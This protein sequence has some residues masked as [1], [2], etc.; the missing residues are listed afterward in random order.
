M[1]FRLRAIDF[2]QEC[3]EGSHLIYMPQFF[4]ENNPIINLGIKSMSP[5]LEHQYQREERMR[6]WIRVQ[7]A[8]TQLQTMLDAM[9]D[10]V[11][12]S[13]ENIH[14]LKHE[15]SEL[16]SDSKFLSCSTMGSIV[17]TSL[18]MLEKYPVR[19]RLK[20]KAFVS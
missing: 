10:D 16:Y 8:G 17:R 19:K 1:Y 7:A 9:E 12:S 4:K 18:R 3:Y 13:P 11:L 20:V 14:Q 5:V 2:D 6:L 15:L